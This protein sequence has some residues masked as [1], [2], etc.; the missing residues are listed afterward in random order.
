MIGTIRG[1]ATH[2][3]PVVITYD[4]KLYTVTF[5]GKDTPC[6]IGAVK[7]CSLMCHRVAFINTLI[8]S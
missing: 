4:C 6:L 3:F 1:H 7:N 5:G 2:L 8:S